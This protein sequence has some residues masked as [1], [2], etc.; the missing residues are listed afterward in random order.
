MT[1][2]HLV[3]VRTFSSTPPHTPMVLTRPTL[4][5]TSDMKI[6]QNLDQ[7]K[8]I[9]NEVPSFVTTSH[10][11]NFTDFP[12]HYPLSKL[13][14][15]IYIYCGGV[16]IPSPVSAALYDLTMVRMTTRRILAHL[17][18]GFKWWHAVFY[19]FTTSKLMQAS[20]HLDCMTNQVVNS[21]WFHINVT[22][23]K[24]S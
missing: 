15:Y 17:N 7:Y 18:M 16:S 11:C 5:F 6:Q 9:Y 21:Q 10:T 4:T 1:R 24:L 19:A 12:S 22:S 20:N 8:Y 2:L 13:K 3:N 14:L 23:G